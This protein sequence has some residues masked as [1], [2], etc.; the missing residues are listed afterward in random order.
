MQ[1]TEVMPVSTDK[2]QIVADYVHQLKELEVE[3]LTLAKVNEELSVKK[4]VIVDDAKIDCE[5]ALEEL[6]YQKQYYEESLNIRK[7]PVKK[8][9][10][11]VVEMLK[12]TAL[13]LV[14]GLFI[15]SLI[16]GII[17]FLFKLPEIVTIIGVAV[18]TLLPSIG[19][20]VLTK[21]DWDKENEKNRQERRDRIEEIPE[22][23][24]RIKDAELYLIECE[25]N[26][27]KVEKQV[28]TIEKQIEMNEGNSARIGVLIRQMHE[29][30]VIPEDYHNTDCI[31]AL[32]HIF[33][34]DLAD[35]VRDAVLMYKE[36]VFQGKVIEGLENIYSMLGN[37]SATMQ[38]M[39]RTLDSID[40]NVSAMA[41]NMDTM[42]DLQKENN[43]TQEQILRESECTRHAAEAIRTSSERCEWY[44]EQHRQGLL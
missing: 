35:T 37:L 39:Q 34:N 13:W 15:G 4:E 12:N 20:I 10:M 7:N 36:W 11:N 8:A 9:S 40:R 29:L 5:D 44:A 27:K 1:E 33:R 19:E 17:S 24:T 21:K 3:R 25:E 16:M 18:C 43:R 31:I 32:D 28:L 30:H 23:E 14:A 26:L 2:K 42:I 41:D 38:Y 6:K 22:C